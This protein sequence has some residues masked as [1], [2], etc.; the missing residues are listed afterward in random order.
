DNGEKTLTFVSNT[1]GVDGDGLVVLLETG[2]IAKK[3]S[4][5]VGENKIFAHLYLSGKLQ[6]EFTPQGTLAER[7]RA[8]GAGVP[9]CFTKTGFGTVI[10]EGKETREIEGENY[11]ME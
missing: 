1:A 2:Q 7:I 9:A 6:L 4:S 3:I 11:V 8:G 10:A 5:Y